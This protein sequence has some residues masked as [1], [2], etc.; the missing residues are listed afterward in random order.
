MKVIV[1]IEYEMNTWRNVSVRKCP[2]NY[3]TQEEEYICELEDYTDDK[4]TR[5]I[6]DKSIKQK[7]QLKGYEQKH[8]PDHP[9]CTNWPVNNK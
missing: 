3:K 4:I 2:P 7:E 8:D 1:T 9:Y 5:N 6:V